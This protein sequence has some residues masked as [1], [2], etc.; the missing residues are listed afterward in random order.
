MRRYAG[1][2]MINEQWEALR[3]FLVDADEFKSKDVLQHATVALALHDGD[4]KRA[5]GILTSECFPTYGS[6]RQSLIELLWDARLMQAE[7]E[8]GAKLTRLETVHLRRKYRCSGDST[9]LTY[10]GKCVIGSPNLGAAYG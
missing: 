3:E 9:S 4:Y 1:W 8:K 2:L 5:M 10:N 6:M 7:A